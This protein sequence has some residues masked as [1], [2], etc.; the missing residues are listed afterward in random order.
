MH[1]V[2]KEYYTIEE[3]NEWAPLPKDY[4]LWNEKIY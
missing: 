2:A 4:K 3:L 1:K